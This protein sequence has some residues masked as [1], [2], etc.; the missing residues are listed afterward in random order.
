ME[1]LVDSMGGICNSKRSNEVSIQEPAVITDRG[2]AQANS[3]SIG[4]E[5]KA[6]SD[7]KLHTI[8][9][10]GIGNSGQTTLFKQLPFIYAESKGVSSPSV[11]KEHRRKQHQWIIWNQMIESMKKILALLNKDN[12]SYPNINS[13][14]KDNDEMKTFD[15]AINDFTVSQEN[16]SDL[17][18]S[19]KFLTEL[20]AD[21][22]LKMT[23]EIKI[24][25]KRVWD[26]KAVKNVFTHFRGKIEVPDSTG[27]FKRWKYSKI[28]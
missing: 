26:D 17:E 23:N 27:L 21:S 8:L 3:T 9:F 2:H 28:M 19:I 6:D 15:T 13:L 1:I 11:A 22:N 20:K 10:L 18:E 25:L 16:N 5:S 24:H 12:A 14:F 4:D 7:T